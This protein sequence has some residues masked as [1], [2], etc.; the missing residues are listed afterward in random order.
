MAGWG[1]EEA[2]DMCGRLAREL[3][4]A[5]QR[6]R[7]ISV[8]V[9]LAGTND[10][11]LGAAPEEVFARVTA[12]HNMA[13]AA[14]ARC[15]AVTLPRFGPQD[16]VF[17]SQTE[18]RGFVNSKLRAV[19]ADALEGRPG[20]PQLLLADFDEAL[21]HLPP[22]ARNVL[23][24]DGVHFTRKGYELL[25]E[26]VHDAVRKALAEIANAPTLQCT[27]KVASTL[28][29]AATALAVTSRAT[30]TPR[31]SFRS[32]PASPMPSRP[33][34]IVKR[35]LAIDFTKAVPQTRTPTP[36]AVSHGVGSAAC[37]VGLAS[38]QVMRAVPAA[39]SMSVM[40][41]VAIR[42]RAAL[43]S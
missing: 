39:C 8:A 43:S 7:P 42:R 21:E 18:R 31:R 12:L 41:P 37:A 38:A 20:S 35:P 9:I 13:R 5:K 3:D 26:V 24:S 16:T 36:T 30:P 19:A 17:A 1:G 4:A 23:F 34:N 33:R 28:P 11:R 10:L 6:S 29:R 15:V 40:Q 32:M 25:G 27:P 22:P 2:K 14:G